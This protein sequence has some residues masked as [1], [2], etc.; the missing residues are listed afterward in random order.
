MTEPID[1]PAGRSPSRPGTIPGV[2]LARDTLYGH[3]YGAWYDRA[4]EWNGRQE[5][6]V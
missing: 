3:L 2:A 4:A 6:P 5:A 1:I